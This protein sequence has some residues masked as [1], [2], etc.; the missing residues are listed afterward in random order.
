MST[1]KEKKKTGAKKLVSR[2]RVTIFILLETWRK[3]KKSFSVDCRHSEKSFNVYSSSSFIF[4][5]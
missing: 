1:L 4:G 3:E 5:P 2:R